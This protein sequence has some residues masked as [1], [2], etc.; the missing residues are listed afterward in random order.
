MTFYWHVSVSRGWRPL[1]LFSFSLKR[2]LYRCSLESMKVSAFTFKDLCFMSLDTLM[3]PRG[4]LL[5]ELMAQ[6]AWGIYRHNNWTGEM[7]GPSICGAWMQLAQPLNNWHKFSVTW[8]LTGTQ[9]TPFFPE[10]P[11]LQSLTLSF[12]HH[13]PGRLWEPLCQ[14][15]KWAN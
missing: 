9:D 5:D 14:A 8:P 13:R 10:I 1:F 11:N 15:L 4:A 6:V 12:L 7:R 3:L 2:N